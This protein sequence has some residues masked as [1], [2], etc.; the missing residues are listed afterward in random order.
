[1]ATTDT[2]CA[3]DCSCAVHIGTIA[4]QNDLF[5]QS[6]PIVA[7]PGRFVMTQAIAARSGDF[8]RACLD[9]VRT[10][11]DFHAGIDPYGTHEMGSFEIDGETVWFRIDLYDERYEYGSPEPTDLEKTRRVLTILFP[12]DY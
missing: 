6:W 4:A 10:C 12:E 9:A 11:D 8:Q 2:A 5:R 1:M 3:E 7:I